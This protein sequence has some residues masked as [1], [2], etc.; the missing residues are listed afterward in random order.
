M[1]S[2]EEL[3]CCLKQ[4]K[5]HEEGKTYSIFELNVYEMLN[6]VIDY[7]ENDNK[8]LKFEELK[9]GMWV[10]DNK[11]KEYIFIF[12]P[13]NWKAIKGL[14]YAN[15]VIYYPTEGYYTVFEENRFFRKQVE[16]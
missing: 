7:L 10:W 15:Q 12:E 3:L 4:V 2:K 5:K 13:L 8:P 11:N 16:E 6:D 9:E 1:L 14:R